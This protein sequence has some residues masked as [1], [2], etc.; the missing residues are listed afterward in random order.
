MAGRAPGPPAD[1]AGPSPT[2]SRRARFPGITRI[3]DHR[4]LASPRRILPALEY[5]E[6]SNQDSRLRLLEPPSQIRPR[7]EPP[8]VAN[9]GVPRPYF[10]RRTASALPEVNERRAKP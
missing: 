8:E 9:T 10:R 2:G 3:P 4:A 7:L 5:A 6:P 1:R